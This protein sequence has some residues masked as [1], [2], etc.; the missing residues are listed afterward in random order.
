[1]STF[2]I[3]L[4]G[5]AL[6]MAGQFAMLCTSPREK[7]LMALREAAR[8]SGLSPRL[9]P[10]PD[11][12]KP[13]HSRG[14]VA[15][16]SLF[17]PEG[18]GRPYWRAERGTDGRWQAVSGKSGLLETLA[19]PPEAASLLALEVRANAVNLYW[20]ESLGSEALPSLVALMRDIME[21]NK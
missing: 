1:M 12:L 19:L 6:L 21:K 5:V 9:I 18:E 8:E 16:Y 11:W 15:C 7:G 14:L 17:V 13:R 2:L 20:D 3:I 10:V 4:G